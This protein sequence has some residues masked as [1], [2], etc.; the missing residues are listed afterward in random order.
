[1]TLMS[2]KSIAIYSRKFIP[3]SIDSLKKIV[4]KIEDNGYKV[5]L[6]RGIF[7]TVIPKI[8]FSENPY[9]FSCKDDLLFHNTKMLFSIGGDGS[10]LDSVRIV[11]DSNI[12]VLGFNFGRM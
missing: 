3:G 4:K 1:I 5:L 9:P 6:H 8:H 11:D 2:R 10:I 7:D 12:P